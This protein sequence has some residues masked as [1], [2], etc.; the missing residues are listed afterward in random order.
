MPEPKQVAPEK[1]APADSPGRTTD[2]LDPLPPSARL[3]HIGLPKTG[4]T[5]LQ[6]AASEQRPELLR[7]GVRYPGRSLNHRVAISALMQRRWGWAGP[8][9]STPSLRAWRDLLAELETDPERRGWI[10]HEFISESDDATAARFAA[11]LGR[12]M[13]VVITLRSFGSLLT[14]SWQQFLKTGT[15][16]TFEHWLRQ[17]LTDPPNLKVTPTFHRR[18]DQAGLVRR[19]AEVAGADQVTVIIVDKHRPWVMP[20]AFE[21]LL[22][23]SRGTLSPDRADGLTGNRSLTAAESELL[24]RLN[25]LVKQGGLGWRQYERL[26]RNG[27]AA[28]LLAARTPTPEEPPVR[29]PDWAREVALERGAAFRDAIAASGVRVVGDLDQLATA[30]PSGE[31]PRP[32]S[33][34][35]DA[36]VEALAGTISVAAGQGIDL[37][38]GLPPA[39]RAE[40]ATAAVPTRELATVLG[41]RIAGRLG[42]GADRAR[43]A[44]TTRLALRTGR[45]SG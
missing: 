9:S 17:V 29:L 18:N 3:L 15:S 13:H 40:R 43:S 2:R 42:A 8:E 4:T 39:E 26:I 32:E 23:L 44:V 14:S 34:P 22:G 41:R 25:L 1:V 24:R 37:E 28:R 5:A 33:V 31:V 6:H 16:H 38:R 10:D 11:E 30:P 19:W 12:S 7:Q 21:D 36:A 35:L 45:G 20:E 27:L